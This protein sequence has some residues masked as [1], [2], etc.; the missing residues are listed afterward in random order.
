MSKKSKKKKGKIINMPL[1]PKNYIRQRARAL[2]IYECL[3]NTEWDEGGLA[4]IFIARRHSNGNITFGSYLVDLLCLGVK[5][6][7][8]W[9][10]VTET[11]YQDFKRDISNEIEYVECDYAL[12]H[13]IIF[14]AIEFA[15]EYGFSPHPDFNFTKYILEEDD[16]NIE[17]IDIEFGRDGKPFLV[18]SPEND[19]A[20]EVAILEK[21]AGPGNYYAVDIDDLDEFE[22]EGEDEYDATE[23]IEAG[24]KG[25]EEM[26]KWKAK[27]WL[28]F[29]YGKKDIEVYPINYV[30]KQ[31]FYDLME[32]EYDDA[33]DEM[34]GFFDIDITEEWFPEAFGVD[35][36][37]DQ[38]KIV[39]SMDAIDEILFEQGNHKEAIGEL[40]SLI[41]QY[42]D[43]PLLRAKLCTYFLEDGNL[44]EMKKNIKALY[45][46]NPDF[47]L[48]KAY[49][50]NYLIGKKRKKEI[51]EI[52]ENKWHLQDFMPE[53]DTFHFTEVIAYYN[54]LL[55]YLVKD[56]ETI[57]AQVLFDLIADNGFGDF[58]SE[59]LMMD[60]TL[61]MNRIVVR[62]NEGV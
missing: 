13:N 37:P 32:E 26:D 16:E 18:T 49:Y 59:P 46:S 58:V 19:F 48:S 52:W 47:L 35:K 25:I 3:I 40:R 38:E 43:I 31:D 6:T 12:A 9:F 28:D 23:L 10:N 41:A 53:R 44:K 42:P 20:R 60:L 17:L 4:T 15:G 54:I 5:D 1:S 27:D 22:D 39:D 36:L 29:E 11:K 45:K 24:V 21:T 34:S 33:F 55:S 30:I 57:R 50:L 2:P 61:Q 51:L 56:N 8:F 62:S 7:G 14:G